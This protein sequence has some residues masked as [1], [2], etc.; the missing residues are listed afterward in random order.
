M[1][2]AITYL[3]LMLAC[4]PPD[5][6]EPLPT[7]LDF[8]LKGWEVADAA[9]TAYHTA[10]TDTVVAM[11]GAGEVDAA[12]RL[13]RKLDDYKGKWDAIS[14]AIDVALDLMKNGQP[15]EADVFRNLGKAQQILVELGVLK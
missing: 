15:S 9:F 13:Q 1:R 3:L 14:L 5:P 7:A 4:H 6:K 10:Q 11:A 8:A 2:N 12:E